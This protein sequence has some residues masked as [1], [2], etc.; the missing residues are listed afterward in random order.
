[1]RYSNI[2]NNTIHTLEINLGKFLYKLR[3]GKAFL[4]MTLNPETLKEKIDK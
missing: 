4:A 2:Q 1:M 3:K